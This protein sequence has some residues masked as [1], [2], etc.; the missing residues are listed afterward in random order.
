LVPSRNHN[1]ETR[2]YVAP[3]RITKGKGFRLKDFNP[4]DTCSLRMNKG[5]ATDLLHGGSAWP[6]EEQHV[7]QQVV[8][9]TPRRRGDCGGNRSLDLAYAKVDAAKKKE[10][11]AAR[12][13]PASANQRMFCHAR[14]P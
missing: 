12:V 8:Q 13:A 6:P 3:Y 7:R 5:E 14:H 4:G 11:A 9:P 10:L 2:K 1:A